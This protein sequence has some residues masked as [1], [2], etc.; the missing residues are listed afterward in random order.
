MAPRKY[1]S[2]GESTKSRIHAI[3]DSHVSA[4][5]RSFH[6]DGS[7]LREGAEGRRGKRWLTLVVVGCLAV[8]GMLVVTRTG[9]GLS[10][11]T[12]TSH[13]GLVVVGEVAAGADVPATIEPRAR[14][15]APPQ[16]PLAFTALNFYQARDGK[17]ALDYPW[18]KDVKVIEPHRDTTLNVTTAREGFQYRWHINAVG[19]TAEGNTNTTA[20]GAECVVV[21]TN[22]DENIITLEEINSDGEIARSLQERVMVKYVRREIRTITDDEREELFDSVSE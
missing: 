18:L 15:S 4:I 16:A 2:L 3:N 22:L 11:T 8:V 17:P 13:A 1:G 10:Q 9:S 19:E 5:N 21:L 12:A 6:E 7:L 20:S 14:V